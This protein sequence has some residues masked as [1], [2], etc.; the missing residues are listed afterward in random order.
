MGIAVSEY[1]PH[2][3]SGDKYARLNAV[4]DMISSGLVWVPETRWA[5]DL[6]DEIAS[7]PYGSNDD[8]VDSSVM[9][10]TRFRQGGFIRLA[11]DLKDDPTPQYQGRREYY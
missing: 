4:A 6:V 7:F 3:G 10:L 8:Q 11:N 2:R 9:A 5:D 1:T